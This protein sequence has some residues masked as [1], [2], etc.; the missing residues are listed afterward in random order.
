MENTS[1]LEKR[2]GYLNDLCS[3]YSQDAVFGYRM[4]VDRL[5]GEAGGDVP[6]MQIAQDFGLS[7]FETD[8]LFLHSRQYWILV[9]NSRL[10]GCIR[11][12]P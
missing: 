9:L 12:L 10:A 3:N 5:D 7:A 11:I 2:L 1:Y 6:L 4:R 8:V